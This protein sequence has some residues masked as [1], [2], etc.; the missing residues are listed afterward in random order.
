MVQKS[1]DKKPPGRRG[2]P[3]AYDPETALAQA[4]AAFWDT[5]YAGT[6][7]DDLSDCTGMN[8]PSLYAAFGDKRALYQRTLDDYR[9]TAREALRAALRYDCPLRAALRGLYDRALSLYLSGEHG[10]R[11]CY[12]IGTALTEAVRD[13]AARA[14]LADAL[15]NLDQA[16]EARIRHARDQG[17]LRDDADPAALATLASAVLH[18]LAIRARA[19]ET[20]EALQAVADAGVALICG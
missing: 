11:G 20:R 4:R 10:A 17:E 9:A 6:S 12:L 13:P 15:R 2:R 5:G 7:L 16:F 18:T 1:P 3:R 19:G 14:A 8:R